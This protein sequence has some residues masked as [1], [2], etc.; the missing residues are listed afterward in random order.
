MA[1]FPPVRSYI[2]FP[3]TP[4]AVSLLAGES[5]NASYYPLTHLADGSPRLAWR[6]VY[7][8][9]A[10]R[11]DLGADQPVNFVGIVG[12]NLAADTLIT[13]WAS[14]VTPPPDLPPYPDDEGTWGEAAQIVLGRTFGV[15]YP[16]CWVDTRNLAGTPTSARYWQLHINNDGGRAIAIN[17]VVIGLAEEFVGILKKPF[18]EKL[19]AFQERQV[20]EYGKVAI[21]GAGTMARAMELELRVTPEEHTRLETIWNTASLGPLDGQRVVVVPDS[22]R[23]DLWYVQWPTRRETTYDK[24]YLVGRLPLT[25]AEEAFGAV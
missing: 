21:S 2:G 20:L 22:R 5:Y 12:H 10:I 17:E 25:L 15:E 3:Y 19:F 16:N 11:F 23:N 7:G 24:S 4:S 1:N 13:V 14:S 8:N 9:V 18:T 6:S